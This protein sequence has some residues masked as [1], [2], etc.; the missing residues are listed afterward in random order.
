MGGYVGHSHPGPVIRF[1][2]MAAL[3]ACPL[4]GLERGS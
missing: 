1:F 4:A 3:R 2:S